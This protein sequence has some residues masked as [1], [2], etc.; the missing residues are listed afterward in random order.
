MTKL[1]PTRKIPLLNGQTI[2]DFWQWGFSNILTNSTRG[3]FA[4]Y[5]VGVA[6][7]AVSDTRIEWDGYDLTY[8]GYGIEV[9]SASYIQDWPQKKLST[10]NFK[11]NKKKCW[12]AADNSYSDT[13]E[14]CADC[15]VFCLYTE[16]NFDKAN[17]LD[18]S[19]W[20][21]YVLSTDYINRTWKNQG[22]VGLNPLRKQISPVS[23]D[24][25]RQTI[26]ER[27]NHTDNT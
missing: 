15:Y 24:Q 11:I 21:F 14:R 17:V 8:Q 19:M 4:E 23:Y 7:D 9:K 16:T 6:L 27:L 10:I 3:V 13:P 2:G 20:E 18:I 25:L 22:S 26:D 1:S 5:I 12:N